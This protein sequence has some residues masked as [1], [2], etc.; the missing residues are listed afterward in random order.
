MVIEKINL[1]WSPEMVGYT[2]H[3]AP[4]TIYHWTYQRQIDFQP[5]QLF[6]HGKRHK[7]R[8]DLRSR[9]NQAVS[10]SIEVRSE[11]ANRRTEKGYLEIDTVRGGRG[12]RPLF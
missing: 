4:H 7:R 10:T 1:G 12:S 2:V 11:S 8:Q 3:C 6:D 9:Y 5:S